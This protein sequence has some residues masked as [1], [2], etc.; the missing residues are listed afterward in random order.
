MAVT[1]RD[2]IPAQACTSSSQTTMATWREEGRQ[3]ATPL[4]EG[5]WV[6][7]SC[8]ERLE[9]VLFNDVT[10]GRSATCQNRPHTQDQ[11]G[12]YK[13]DLMEEWG[14]GYG[15]ESAKLGGLRGKGVDSEWKRKWGRGERL[16]I[17]ND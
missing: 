14:W 9:W 15:E 11:F 8:W 13:L 2:N 16:Y 17:L 12:Q 4:G 5:L 6:A 7:D 1:Y 3:E 10:L